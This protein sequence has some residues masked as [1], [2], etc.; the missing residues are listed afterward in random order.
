MDISDLEL[1]EAVDE[2]DSLLLEYCIKH[3]FP[4]LMATSIVMSRLLHLNKQFGEVKDFSDLLKV[5]SK[6]IDDEKY[7]KPEKLH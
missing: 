3:K 2:F 1:K 7:E 5:I 6:N 4:A